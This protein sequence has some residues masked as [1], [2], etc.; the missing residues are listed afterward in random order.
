MLVN[1]DG[2]CVV[3]MVDSHSDTATP[4]AVSETQDVTLLSAVETKLE[5]T[6]LL[7]NSSHFS[8]VKSS[9]A[10]AWFDIF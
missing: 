7:G 3:A 5:I 6:G 9:Y 2:G 10:C 8:T 4:L 1:V